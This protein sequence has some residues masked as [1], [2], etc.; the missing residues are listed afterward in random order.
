MTVLTYRAGVKKTKIVAPD[1]GAQRTWSWPIHLVPETWS[2]QNRISKFSSDPVETGRTRTSL[3]MFVMS[4]LG[5]VT[6]LDNHLVRPQDLE[7]ETHLFNGAYPAPDRTLQP[8]WFRGAPRRAASRRGRSTAG[9]R[10]VDAR[11]CDR[12]G[13]GIGSSSVDQASRKRL[14]SPNHQRCAGER[15]Q[16][17][18]LTHRFGPATYVQLASEGARARS[19]GLPSAIASR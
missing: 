8:R 17:R 5:P 15:R 13:P 4:F 14:A 6:T 1:R 3:R 10:D 9:T 12:Q 16:S 19:A 2:Q 18:P 11:G 7:I